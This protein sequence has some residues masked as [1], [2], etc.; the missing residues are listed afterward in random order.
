MALLLLL[1]TDG[2]FYIRGGTHRSV[3]VEFGDHVVVVEGPLNEQR[4][5][6]VI[7]EV[8][9][10]I[11][12]KPIRIWSTYLHGPPLQILIVLRVQGFVFFVLLVASDRVCP[13]AR[14]GE[15]RFPGGLG[16]HRA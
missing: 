4:S 3:A 9:K 2:V 10:L 11:P 1:L 15:M 5:L 7:A 13:F 8:K 14:L 12:N 6:A 16:A